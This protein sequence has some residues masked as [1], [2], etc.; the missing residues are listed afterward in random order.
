MFYTGLCEVQ[1]PLLP[2]NTTYTVPED[3]KEDCCHQQFEEI[4]M[5]LTVPWV[6]PRARK[7]FFTLGH[8]SRL[9][10]SMAI[11]RLA[12]LHFFMLTKSGGLMLW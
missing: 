7:S 10:A 5:V 1:C 4:K 6:E 11:G 9:K 3:H 12:D 2:S 8:S